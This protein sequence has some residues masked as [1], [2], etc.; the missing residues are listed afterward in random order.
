MPFNVGIPELLIFYVFS[1]VAMLVHL[2][3]VVALGQRKRH[4]LGI[5]LVTFLLGWTVIGWVGALAWAL[6]SKS[7]DA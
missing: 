4:T 5:F 2:P 7:K 1:A 3:W 6:L